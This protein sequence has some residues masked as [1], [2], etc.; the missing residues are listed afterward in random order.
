MFAEG[1][2]MYLQGKNK[3]IKKPP[4][5]NQLHLAAWCTCPYLLAWL[6]FFARIL[7]SQLP[8]KVKNAMCRLKKSKNKHFLLTHYYFSLSSNPI[9]SVNHRKDEW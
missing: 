1:E 7:T 2:E 3:Q 8:K 6:S 4:K 9:A 5:P